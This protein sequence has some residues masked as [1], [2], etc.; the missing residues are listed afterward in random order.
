[1][2]HLWAQLTN[3]EKPAGKPARKQKQKEAVAA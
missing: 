2:Q 1:V 3:P